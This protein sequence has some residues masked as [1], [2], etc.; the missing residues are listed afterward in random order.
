M[1][2]KKNKTKGKEMIDQLT[3]ASY[4]KEKAMY[5]SYHGLSEKEAE[6]VMGQTTYQTRDD[7][8]NQIIEDRKN[9]G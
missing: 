7:V 9:N 2:M 4:S 5:M 3:G 8:L 6:L 1:K